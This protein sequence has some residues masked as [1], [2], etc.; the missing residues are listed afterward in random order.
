MNEPREER[1]MSWYRQQPRSFKILL[2]ANLFLVAGAA[3][4]YAFS[5]IVHAERTKTV[6]GKPCRVQTGNPLDLYIS[7]RGFFQVELP[8]GTTAYTRDGSF[9][10]STNGSVVTQEGHLLEPGLTLP[11]D[12]PQVRVGLDGLV[13]VLG[14]QGAW[15]NVGQL[16]LAQFIDPNGLRPLSSSGFLR[17]TRESGAP[18]VGQPGLEG[19]GYVEQGFLESVG[20][21]WMN[22]LFRLLADSE[23]DVGSATPIQNG[24]GIKQLLIVVN[25]R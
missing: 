8:D 22:E 9:R 5:G 24:D 21:E 16:Q 12:C 18:S 25:L 23:L 20:D 13:S 1:I 11:S 14:V 2:A 3:C 4:C 10:L 6:L 17:E 7:G 15:V 19:L